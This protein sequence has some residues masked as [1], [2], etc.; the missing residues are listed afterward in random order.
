MEKKIN[1]NSVVK[2]RVKT[3]YEKLFL[4]DHHLEFSDFKALKTIPDRSV[5]PALLALAK[6][7]FTLDGKVTE[8]LAFIQ[9][10][11]E[12]ITTKTY[13][14]LLPEDTKEYF[15]KTKSDNIMDAWKA[16]IA[17]IRVSHSGSEQTS[18]QYYGHGIEGWFD[19]STFATFWKD[20]TSMKD[21]IIESNETRFGLLGYPDPLEYCHIGRDIQHHNQSSDKRTEKHGRMQACI[22]LLVDQSELFTTNLKFWY[23]RIKI[24]N[25]Y[26]EL[27]NTL[28][29]AIIT[30]DM[31]RATLKDTDAASDP[32][33]DI[34]SIDL[35]RTEKKNILEKFNSQF[36]AYILFRCYSHVQSKLKDKEVLLKEMS[37]SGFDHDTVNDIDAFFNRLT[38]DRKASNDKI[39]KKFHAARKYLRS[40]AYVSARGEQLGRELKLM[41]ENSTIQTSVQILNQRIDDIISKLQSRCR[42]QIDA[43]CTE[44]EKKLFKKFG[45]YDEQIQGLLETIGCRQLLIMQNGIAENIRALISTNLHEIRMKLEYQSR[46]TVGDPCFLEEHIVSILTDIKDELKA[47]PEF[48]PTDTVFTTIAIIR[49]IIRSELILFSID[50]YFTDIKERKEREA[51]E[52]KELEVVEAN[53]KKRKSQSTTDEIKVVAKKPNPTQSKPSHSHSLS[54]RHTKHPAKK[55][56]YTTATRTSSSTRDKGEE[57]EEEEYEDDTYDNKNDIDQKHSNDDN[58]E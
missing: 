43:N 20:V 19:D 58:D 45:E 17:L 36:I 50:E 2:N 7:E 44:E 5:I 31:L 51:R 8:T 40:S 57:E 32:I 24:Q 4:F 46:L 10:E 34:D 21:V 16:V 18:L 14:A 53:N 26:N 30:N 35:T 49:V 3:V 23:N 47:F 29:S 42:K 55:T 27:T 6:R 48:K 12:K 13:Y 52:Q 15:I 28:R 33:G 11:S 9:S 54:S 39:D 37:D 41:I 38:D 22:N 1:I 56:K 25:L